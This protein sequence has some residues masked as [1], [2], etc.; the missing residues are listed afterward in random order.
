MKNQK[1]EY[2]TVRGF[3]RAQY[4]IT[5]KH[6]PLLCKGIKGGFNLHKTW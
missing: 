1:Q 4:S 6:D 3:R 2:F 5:R